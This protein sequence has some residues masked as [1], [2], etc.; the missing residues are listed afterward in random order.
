MSE[1]ISAAILFNKL[2]GILSGPVA[3]LEL[4]VFSKRIT[5]QVQI[6]LKQ[7]TVFVDWIYELK[8]SE[9]PAELVTSLQSSWLFWQWLYESY[10]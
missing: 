10:Q 8:V 9:M 1:R 2:P 5:V 4:I 3:L 7:K 6:S